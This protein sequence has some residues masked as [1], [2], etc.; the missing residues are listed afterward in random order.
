MNQ[1]QPYITIGIIARNEEKHIITTLWHLIN[2]SYPLEKCEIIIADGWSTDQTRQLAEEFLKNNNIN[3]KVINERTYKNIWNWVGFWPSFWRNVIINE[4]SSKSNYIAWIDADCRAEKNRL[5]Q[6]VKA[7]VWTEDSIVAAG[8][9][10][11]VETKWNISKRELMINYYFTSK[12]MTMWNPAFTTRND[13]KFVESLAWYNSIYKIE[14]LKKYMY[15]TKYAFNNDDIEINFR[16]RRDWYQLAYTPHAKIYHRQDETIRE[17]LKHLIA[18]GEWAA[19]TTKIHKAFPRIYV[20]LSVGYLLYTIWLI[21]LLPILWNI[22]LIPYIL[23]LWIALLVFI[24]NIIQTK[25]LQ[26]LKVFILV[27]WHPF[28][29]GYGFLREILKK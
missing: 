17:F 26:S 11:L 29:Y 24:E 19:R 27:F 10:R 6:L 18:Y 20:P 28:M 3:H 5:S 8:W 16:L 22:I 23:V 13:I 12:I 9:P 21:F 2:Q 4:A 15:S 1:N 14:I 25:S 7:I